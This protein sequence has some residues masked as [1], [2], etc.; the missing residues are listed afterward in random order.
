M[1]VHHERSLQT[2]LLV[3]RTSFIESSGR[4]RG[5]IV[6][7]SAILI[8]I[9]Q[10]PVIPI[11]VPIINYHS[12]MSSFSNML[13]FLAPATWLISRTQRKVATGEPVK[14]SAAKELPLAE[15][16]YNKGKIDHLTLKGTFATG[17]ST[18]LN[19]GY[20]TFASDGSLL[21][22][23]GVMDWF[24]GNSGG[25]AAAGSM[26]PPKR[27]PFSGSLTRAATR[28]P[29]QSPSAHENSPGG[30]FFQI[31]SPRRF[32]GASTTSQRRT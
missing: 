4:G 26:K 2:R 11:Q 30:T 9:S 31:H 13:C 7:P 3:T 1:T 32:I 14:V 28:C 8:W 12:F 10:S 29:F 16:L 20:A 15:D 25:A 27:Y 23:K 18:V 21:A 24:C 19:T 17:T 22:G 5:S 6:G